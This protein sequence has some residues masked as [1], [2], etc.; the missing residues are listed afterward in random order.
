MA[1]V[2]DLVERSRITKGP[3][4]RLKLW[5]DGLDTKAQQ[6]VCEAF[7]DH[8][9]LHRVLSDWIREQPDAPQISA[10]NVSHHR[11]GNCAGCARAGYDLVRP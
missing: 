6:Q 3:L 4:C 8:R 7:R 9:V 11:T 10:S 2:D 1:L 5:L